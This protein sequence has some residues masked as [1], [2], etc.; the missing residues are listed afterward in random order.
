MLYMYCTI[1]SSSVEKRKWPDCVRWESECGRALRGRDLVVRSLLVLWLL[2]WTIRGLC[3]DFVSGAL[4][5]EVLMRGESCSAR[6][7]LVSSVLSLTV[8]NST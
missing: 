1:H 7:P 4:V 2:R 8:E 3:C 6:G 5:P